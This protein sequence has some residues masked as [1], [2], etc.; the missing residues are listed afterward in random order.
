MRKP[1]EPGDLQHAKRRAGNSNSAI[2]PAGK[3]W[4]GAGGTV[5]GQ[6][7]R[8]QLGSAS[9]GH[10]VWGHGPRATGDSTSGVKFR[11]SIPG[12]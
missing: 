1:Q 10:G 12:C 4:S 2:H 3:G 11:V 8:L 6:L 9:Q 5:P 7:P